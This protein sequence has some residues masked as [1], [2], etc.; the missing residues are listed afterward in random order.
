MTELMRVGF[1]CTEDIDPEYF[2]ESVNALLEITKFETLYGKEIRILSENFECLLNMTEEELQVAKETG[3]G[4]MEY[5]AK[6]TS[7]KL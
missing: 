7:V 2:R 4:L 6:G 3:E 5:I 1:A